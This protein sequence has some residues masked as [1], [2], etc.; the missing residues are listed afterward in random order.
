MEAIDEKMKFIKQVP[1][2]PEDRLHRIDRKLK[3]STNRMENIED[4]V[5][6]DNVSKLMRGE[7]DFN[8]EKNAK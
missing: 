2:H 6:T 7:F 4:Q 5:A 3:H 8:P 1:S